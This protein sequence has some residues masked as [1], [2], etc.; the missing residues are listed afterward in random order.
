MNEDNDSPI[1]LAPGLIPDGGDGR[2]LLCG[3]PED[4]H[5]DDLDEGGE[6]ATAT[7]GNSGVAK[8]RMRSKEASISLPVRD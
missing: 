4:E 7:T 1:C 6:P 5:P 8:R 2:C 3:M